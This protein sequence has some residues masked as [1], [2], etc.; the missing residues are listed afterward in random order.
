M[1]FLN[2]KTIKVSG[3][4]EVTLHEMGALPYLDY[5]QY[6]V[7]NPVNLELEGIESEREILRVY[8]RVCAHGLLL[9]YPD[10][11]IDEIQFMV[12]TEFRPADIHRLHDTV[13]ELCGWINPEEQ[14][15][16]DESENQ[17]FEES[18]PLSPKS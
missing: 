10:K 3:Q 2:S 4:Q 17:N 18:E 12:Q 14:P 6:L 11:T 9:S 5:R 16:L 1:P 13:A 7:D 15:D 8:S